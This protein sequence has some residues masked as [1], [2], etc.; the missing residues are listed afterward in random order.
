MPRTMLPSFLA[1]LFLAV[2]AMADAVHVRG[3][4]APLP[5]S[6][7]E[8]VEGGRVIYTDLSGRRQDRSCDEVLTISF[9]D[10]ALLDK[11]ES[12]LEG[13]RSE[14]G[15]RALLGALLATEVPMQRRWIMCR[16]AAVHDV[17]GEY[18]QACSHLARLLVEDPHP[19]W[20]RLKPVT[21]PAMTTPVA[22]HEAIEQVRRARNAT[23]NGDLIATLAEIRKQLEAMETSRGTAETW[24]GL[25]LEEI[26][27]DLTTEPGSTPSAGD[28]G[29]EKPGDGGMS[30]D[31]IE[32]LL[33]A[34]RYED[35]L[36][37]C[38]TAAEARDDRSMA[39]LL[40]QAGRALAG[41]G[42]DREAIVMLTRSGLLFPTSP[43]A[44][45]SLAMAA[46]LARS[47]W[48]GTGTDDS[49]WREALKAAKRTGDHEIEERAHR[50]LESGD[51]TDTEGG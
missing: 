5:G 50:A 21:A 47:Q 38:T 32:A 13:G 18:P 51:N 20:L 9:K 19:A 40:E 3:T 7:V 11:A 17:R 45:R 28:A 26:Q 46:E 10:N 36:V 48:P 30:Q 34:G 41:T 49:L 4:S 2:A 25:T 1:L 14:E 33:D 15:V 24:S 35:A 16:L 8:A 6:R 12:H 42:Q 23:D 22:V 27:G 29:E 31:A 43:V 39:R 44:A 37:A